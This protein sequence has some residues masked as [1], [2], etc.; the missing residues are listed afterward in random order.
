MSVSARAAAL[1]GVTRVAAV[2]GT[3]ANRELLLTSGFLPPESAG[4]GDL[5]VAIQGTDAAA[6]QAASAIIEEW[7]GAGGA[8]VGPVVGPAPRSLPAAVRQLRSAN[9]AVISV[10]GE[11]AAYLAD[12]ALDQRLHVFL[13]SNGVPT[14]EEARLKARAAELGL[15]V[16]GPDCGTAIIGG[17]ALG[18]A[19][20]VR[21]GSI[22]IVAA[23]GTGAQEVSTLLH[24]LGFGVSHIIGTGGRD[25][26]AAVGGVTMRAGI[27]L[28]AED[29]QT[30]VLVLISK[31][32]APHVAEQMRQE[33]AAA[34]KAGVVC[35]L[36][37]PPQ[38]AADVQTLQEAALKAAALAGQTGWVRQAAET[39]LLE[40]P[41]EELAVQAAASLAPGQRYLR[42]L[43][44][45]G[46]LCQEAALLLRPTL[47]PLVGEEAAGPVHTA[48]DF[49][50]ERYT[51]GRP[52]PMIDPTLR[53]KALERAASDP[54]VGVVLLDVVL[55][56]SA[57]PDPASVLVPVIRSVQAAAAA[58]GRGLVVIASL[59]GTDRDPQGYAAQ[60]GALERA[61]VILAPSNAQ[62][63]RLAAAVLRL[64]TR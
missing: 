31:S 32:P 18:F 43:Y 42:A 13:F 45:G 26:A 16:M 46:T 1:A 28:L 51:R 56:Y 2:M 49:G 17:T 47:G 9:L 52:H 57:H 64:A 21:R 14:A 58:E 6:C 3:P 15:L 33:L 24:K 4:P 22:G 40:F 8:P 63:A 54:S 12:Q 30:D 59:C 35:F 39:T 37:Q 11:Y 48:I 41:L 34:G 62:A 10:P 61:G 5:I 19:N 55:G 7:L 36:G 20:A 44:S 60:V 27:R 25:L 50:D 29:P 38:G 23:S 53:L